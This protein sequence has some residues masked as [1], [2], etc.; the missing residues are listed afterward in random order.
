MIGAPKYIFLPKYQNSNTYNTCTRN[1]IFVFLN[2]NRNFF[3]DRFRWAI[4]QKICMYKKIFLIT[5]LTKLE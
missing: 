3:L 1:K 5:E 2:D 4:F